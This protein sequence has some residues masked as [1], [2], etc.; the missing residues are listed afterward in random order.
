MSTPIPLRPDVNA[1]LQSTRRSWVRAVTAHALAAGSRD[2]P[3]KILKRAWPGD[4]RAALILRGGVSQTTSTDYPAFDPVAP[5][6]SIAP[7]AALPKLLSLGLKLD[8]AHVHS[9]KIP[10]VA[11][12]PPVPVFIG[13]GLPG[14]NL[15]WSF[16][17]TTLGPLKKFLVLSAVTGEIENGNPESTAAV[18]GKVLADA[19]NKSLDTIA[20]DTNAGDAIR[21]PG[22]LHGVTPI[23][24][25]GSGGAEPMEHDLA[26]L[27]KAIGDAGIDPSDTVFVAPPHE[28]MLIKLRAGPKFDHTVLM[29]IG[30]PAGTVCAFAPAAIASGFAGVPTI[31]TS[32]DAAV[33]FEDTAPLDIGGATAPVKSAFQTDI[34]SI[35]VRGN[36]AYA[37]APGGVQTV[38]GINW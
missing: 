35:K 18:I 21:P 3:A 1:V 23:M 34:I 4:D 26:A 5:Y 8:M 20:F 27:T 16:A 28:A 36:V 29:S 9:F 10:N 7:G 12:L 32:K 6:R 14:A 17:S 37:V 22:L 38:S 2:D 31:E 25:T 24:P 11:G 13:E 19:A 30:L 33:H 15:Q